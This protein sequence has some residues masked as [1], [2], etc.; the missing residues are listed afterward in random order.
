MQPR[1]RAERGT[2]GC[3]RSL[4]VFRL[5]A[6]FHDE[7][8]ILPELPAA[9]SRR[10]AERNGR[11]EQGLCQVTAAARPDCAMGPGE[12]VATG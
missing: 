5:A 3:A 11:D 2:H 6:F 4:W 10:R 9:L 8:P 1:P 12:L 7:L